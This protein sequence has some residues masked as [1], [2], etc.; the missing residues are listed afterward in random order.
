MVCVRSS[1]YCFHFIWYQV[2]PSCNSTYESK[3]GCQIFFIAHP[4]G[5]S[6]FFL[7]YRPQ[8]NP[9]FIF[10]GREISQ[11]IMV[12]LLNLPSDLVLA[13]M[14]GEFWVRFLGLKT[15]RQTNKQTV[16]RENKPCCLL[17]ILACDSWKC[18]G[19]LGALTWPR[20]QS[21]MLSVA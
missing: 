8:F 3:P 12:I 17:P 2:A 18:S 11:P 9:R 6:P 14:W 4:A 16:H 15:K 10:Q 5:I 13:E 19:L 1:Q 20:G 21:N 7:T